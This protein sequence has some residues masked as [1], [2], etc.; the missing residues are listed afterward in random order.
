MAIQSKSRIN[1]TTYYD[2]PEYQQY[3]LIQLIHG[4]VIFPMPPIPLHQ[5]IVGEI[6]YLFMTIARK[7]NSKAYTSPIEV[8]LDEHNIFEPDVLFLKSD[9]S[10]EVEEKRLKGAP[11]LVV[12]VLSP[13]TAKYDRQE[14]YQ[15]YQKHGINEYWIADP[16]HQTIEVW[17][18]KA[19]QFVRQGAYGVDDSFDSI[20]LKETVH[21]SDIFRKPAD[22]EQS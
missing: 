16:T 4:E 13:G 6:L 14:K 20:T 15:V 1:A 21:L 19:K 17:T 5:Q 11:D 8:Y 18:L 12:E 22:E 9:S 3:D 2:L 7:T 10:C